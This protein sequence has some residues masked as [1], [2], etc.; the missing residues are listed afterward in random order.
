MGKMNTYAS[1]G[2]TSVLDQFKTPPPPNITPF[3]QIFKKTFLR[4]VKISIFVKEKYS[5]LSFYQPIAGAAHCIF[6]FV[7]LYLGPGFVSSSA[8][9]INL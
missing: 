1:P 6:S 7:S 4:L 3:L 2:Y 5:C 8:L 9:R